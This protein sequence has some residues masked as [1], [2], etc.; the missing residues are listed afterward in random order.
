MV[1]PDRVA[2]SPCPNNNQRMPMEER[3]VFRTQNSLDEG[4]VSAF[5]L[6]EEKESQ[7]RV[8]SV[9]FEEL[10]YLYDLQ[11]I[12][13]REPLSCDD[14]EEEK[15]ETG[16]SQSNYQMSSIIYKGP[17]SKFINKHHNL[18]KRYLVLNMFGLFVYKDE[19]AF[20]SFPQKPAVVIPMAEISCINQREFLAQSM[21]KNQDSSMLPVDE[22]IHVMEV[23][24]KHRYH[25]VQAAIRNFHYPQQDVT[26][27]PGQRRDFVE[28]KQKHDHMDDQ[29]FVF[30]D[31][32]REIIKELIKRSLEVLTAQKNL[33][34]MP[35]TVLPT[36]S[37]EYC[38]QERS[39][40]SPETL[41]VN[42]FKE[43]EK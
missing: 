12:Y 28:P 4:V 6:D 2:M 42:G 37:V 27:Q 19:Q 9:E 39:G 21:F 14:E 32:S 25:K 30:V 26:K 35:E 31:T 16:N 23:T 13:P 40:A 3:K 10:G 24:L 5:P 29:G 36:K 34:L 38:T 1:S 17:I 8:Q 20:L 11:K 41:T 43:Y 7:G 18:V 33:D 22:M 15:H